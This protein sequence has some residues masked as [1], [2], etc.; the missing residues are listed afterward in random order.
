MLNNEIAEEMGDM[1][2]GNDTRARKVYILIL[3]NFRLESAYQCF[4]QHLSM[5][6]T[7][8]MVKMIL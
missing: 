6:L 4:Q 5:K 7:K 8:L 3:A 2:A 1:D